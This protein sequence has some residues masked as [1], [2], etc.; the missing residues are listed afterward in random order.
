MRTGIQLIISAT[1]S[2]LVSSTF[3]QYDGAEMERN[4][5]QIT[6][7]RSPKTTDKV[8][9]G[10]KNEKRDQASHTQEQSAAQPQEEGEAS[11]LEVV[12]E[13]IKYALIAA[14][15]IL[16]I[17]T[18]IA[19]PFVVS[20][21]SM[22]PT[23]HNGEYL[24]V[25]ELTKYTGTYERGDV[26]ILKYPN[27]PSKYFIKRVIGLPRE[28]VSI[29]DGEVSITSPTQKTPLVLKETYVKQPK[30]DNS[31]RTL[32]ADEYFVMGDNRA[33]SSDS[34]VWGPVPKRLM[35]GK[36]LLRLYPFYGIALHPGSIETFNV[37][38]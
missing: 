11:M 34:R 21:N 20:G 27:D 32:D 10:E 33:Q 17:R 6:D 18:F 37:S 3:F 13:T 31:S 14:V 16:P 38:Y 12:W 25:N 4:E 19:Q 30:T 1:R 8:I 35:D 26:V 28:T 24:I 2:S 36:A 9:L 15:I 23:F 29:N 7:L 22:Y 5:H